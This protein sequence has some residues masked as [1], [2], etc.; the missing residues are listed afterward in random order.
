MTRIAVP[1]LLF[2]LV[3]T[4]L[5]AEEKPAGGAPDLMSQKPEQV[6]AKNANCVSCHTQTDSATM[7]EADVPLACV[8]CHGGDVSARDKEHA[9]VQPSNPATFR[10]SAN[11]VRPAA[12]TL[13]ESADFIRFLNPADLRVAAETCGQSGCH[14]EE[15]HKV[16]RSMKIGRAHV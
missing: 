3:I 5:V 16:R 14:T 6:A 4:P 9:H 11:P 1:A 10:S 8:D 13:L 12:A 15:V 2:A 7:H